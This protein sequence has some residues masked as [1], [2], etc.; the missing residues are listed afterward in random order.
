M[1]LA[2]DLGFDLVGFTGADLGTADFE[3]YQEWVEEGCAAEMG[4]LERD[5][6]RRK[7]VEEIMPEAHSVICLGI[8]YYPGERP[9]R[10]DGFGTVARY[11]HGQ[12]YHEVV[13][14][15]LGQL[16]E[17]LREKFPE[18]QFKFYVDTGAVLERAYSAAARLGMISEN[19]TL[20]TPK[21]GSWVFLSEVITD[22]E[23]APS[24]P[25]D[26]K[27][28]G[29]C[30][31]CLEACPT[32]AFKGAY[33]LDARKCISY[34]T[35]ENKG[36]IPEELRAL[37]GG[38]LFGCDV[39]QEICPQNLSRAKVTRHKAFSKPVAGH[40]LD[41]EVILKLRTKEEFLERFG[42]SPV[43]RARREGLV[44]N[45]CVVAANTGAKEL[46]LLLEEVA[47]EDESEMVREHAAWAIKE[48]DKKD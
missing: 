3:R 40:F 35:I 19:T 33:S 42:G 45:A 17:K 43:K 26:E 36:A 27:L 15:M 38:C 16:T 10:P 25:P 32:N 24:E 14:D 9:E 7:S 47:R 23:L 21:F 34:L 41:L 6:S 18:N 20:V 2:E 31:A 46:L 13:S 11:A 30:H 28:C 12:D 8:N 1:R 4:Y 37:I 39:C 48:L 29:G 22:L 5:V 44:R